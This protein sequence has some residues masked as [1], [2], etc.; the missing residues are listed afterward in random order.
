MLHSTEELKTE[1]LVTKLK[2]KDEA[3]I[4]SICKL[5][6]TS[7]K[8]TE[9][10]SKGDLLCQSSFNQFLSGEEECT[11]HLTDYANKQFEQVRSV[12]PTYC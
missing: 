12:L 9:F 6:K 2:C 11:S 1:L 10:L 4:E 8:V 5:E 3:F 7:S